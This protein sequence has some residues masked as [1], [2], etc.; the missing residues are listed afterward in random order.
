MEG[1][2]VGSQ[3]H[4]ESLEV[5]GRYCSKGT[6]WAK[7]GKGKEDGE[8]VMHCPGT[9]QGWEKVQEEEGTASSE[10]RLVLGSCEPTVLVNEVQRWPGQIEGAKTS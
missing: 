3:S 5:T 2:K 10:C 6:E 1:S 8:V 9:E 7:R 4:R